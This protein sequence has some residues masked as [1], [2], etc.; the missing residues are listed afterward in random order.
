MLR[1]ASGSWMR[2]VLVMVEGKVG[3]GGRRGG[4][5]REAARPFER[6]F[7]QAGGAASHGRKRNGIGTKFCYR[8]V[9]EQQRR[10]K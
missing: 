7:V 4:R 6:S 5:E 8:T 10:G 3:G 1:L 2:V 9:Y